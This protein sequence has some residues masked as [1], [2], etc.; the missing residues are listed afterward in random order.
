LLICLGITAALAGVVVPAVG[1]VRESAVRTACASNLRQVGSALTNYRMTNAGSLPIRPSGLDQTNPHVLKY[2]TLPDSM[3][4]EMQ[5]AAG[6]RDIYYCPA[7]FQSR[8]A[9]EWW[10]YVSGTIAITYQFPFWLK[11]TCWLVPMPNYA[12]MD[13]EVVLATDY[14]GS[15]P[16]GTS[17]LA[18]NHKKS[19]DGWPAGM[20]LLL[21]DGHVEWRDHRG[22][23]TAWGRSAGPIDWFWAQ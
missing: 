1:V 17:A 12:R 8:T 16:G 7:N 14:L 20:N 19:S 9:R 3:A 15:N 6:S 11:D 5:E 18:W 21:G 10:P 4:R 2:V 23:Y 13:P 22:G